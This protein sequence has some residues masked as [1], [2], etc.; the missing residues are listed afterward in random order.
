MTTVAFTEP[1]ARAFRR[2]MAEP[3]D[4]DIRGNPI[5]RSACMD[6]ATR[7]CIEFGWMAHASTPNVREQELQARIDALMLEHCPEEMSVEQIAEWRR[8]QVAAKNQPE[9]KL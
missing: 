6:D 1:E 2:F 5:S 8:H 7:A 3:V 9:V 4:S